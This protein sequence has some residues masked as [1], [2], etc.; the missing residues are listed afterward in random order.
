MQ[1]LQARLS[2]TELRKAVARSAVPNW[3][4]ALT[5]RWSW[6]CAL[7]S[8][9]FQILTPTVKPGCVSG[10]HLYVIRAADDKAQRRRLFD[11]LRALGVG[12]QVHYEPVHHHPYY[13]S[14]GFDPDACPN[15]IEFASRAISLPIFPAMTND[16]ILWVVEQV[17]TAVNET[18]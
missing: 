3:C 12:V 13:R 16:D 8:L 5:L 14:L 15:A 10:W 2:L 9:F 11:K 7:A 17:R 4:G 6:S 18:R 1:Q